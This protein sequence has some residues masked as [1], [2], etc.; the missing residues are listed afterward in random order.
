MGAVD[1]AFVMIVLTIT[2]F[3]VGYAFA[4]IDYRGKQ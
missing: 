2:G 3:V 4:K 1:M